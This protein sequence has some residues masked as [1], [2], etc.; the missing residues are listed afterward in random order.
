MSDQPTNVA[1][2]AENGADGELVF[3]R[4]VLDSALSSTGV[5]VTLASGGEEGLTFPT[6][7][8]FWLAEGPHDDLFPDRHQSLSQVTKEP[9]SE[10]LA[11][12]LTELD[13]EAR[14]R[15]DENSLATLEAILRYGLASD[16][17]LGYIGGRSL[18]VTALQ[19]VARFSVRNTWIGSIRGPVMPSD[20]ADFAQIDSDLA[21]RES[22]GFISGP[23]RSTFFDDRLNVSEGPLVVSRAPGTPA[24]AVQ[25]DIATQQDGCVE[26]RTSQGDGGAKRTTTSPGLRDAPEAGGYYISVP[27]LGD[28]PEWVPFLYSA[29]DEAAAG[30]SQ[31]MHGLTRPRTDSD[32]LAIGLSERYAP[33]VAGSERERR[34]LDIAT[35]E[36]AM[37][38]TVSRHVAF[39]LLLPEAVMAPAE[40]E[41]KAL[42]AVLASCQD[43]LGRA[44]PESA[45]SDHLKREWDETS[46][47]Q[48]RLMPQVRS[49]RRQLEHQLVDHVGGRPV[50][51]L[52]RARLATF[53]P[54]SEEVK[55]S[56]NRQSTLLQV[57]N[58]LSP[59]EIEV[60]YRLFTT[61]APSGELRACFEVEATVVGCDAGEA[62]AL[63][64]SFGELVHAAFVGAYGLTFTFSP[65]RGGADDEARMRHPRFEREI[66][67]S[68]DPTGALLPF[69]GRPDWGY[70]LDYLLTLDDPVAIK[71]RARAGGSSK[72][73][74]LAAGDVPDRSERGD[75][76]ATS[77]LND[78]LRRAAQTDEQISLRVSVGSNREVSAPLL[79]LVGTEVSGPATFEVAGVD[80]VDRDPERARMTLAEAFGIFHAPYGDFFTTKIGQSV[81]RISSAI[82]TFPVAGIE[83]GSA[84]RAHAKADRMIKLRISETDALRHLYVVGRTGSGKTNFLRGL[85]AQHLL[86]PGTGIAVIDPHGDLA[87]HVLNSVPAA[88]VDEVVTVDVTDT[89]LMPVLNPL[90]FD[91]AD[92]GARSRIVQDVLELIKQRLY[93][94]WSGPR[95]DEMVRLALD[96][97]LDGGYPVA[98]SL[99]DVPR[100]LTDAGLQTGLIKRLRDPELVARWQFHHRLTTT[101]E[102]PDL[103]DWVVSKFDDIS[104]DESL[105]MILG[106]ERN[107]VDI[108]RVVRENGILIVRLPEAEV[109]RQAAEFVGSLVLQQLRGALL[110]RRASGP[111]AGHFFVY[112]DEFQKFATTAFAELVAE[113]RKY[114]VGMVLAHQ[115]LEQLKAFSP[116]SGQHDQSLLSAILGNV[117]SMVCFGVGAPDTET[118]ASQLGVSSAS[119][120][121]I[122]RYEALARVSL[123]G[124]WVPTMTLVTRLT[125]PELD[126]RRQD[127]I[128]AFQYDSGR[129]VPRSEILREIET[130]R[131]ALT[132][133][134]AATT[135]APPAAATTATTFMEEWRAARDSGK[136]P[137]AAPTLPVEEASPD[138]ESPGRAER[139]ERSE[140]SPVE[141][142]P[143][144]DDRGGSWADVI[145]PVVRLPQVAEAIGESVDIV[146][147][148]AEARRMLILR[149]KNDTEVV[150]VSHFNDGRVVLGLDEVLVA[151]SRSG[152][153]AWST[154]AWLATP[155]GG[156]GGKSVIEWLRAGLDPQMP[157]ILAEGVGDGE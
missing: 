22:I 30:I 63:R 69:A 85:A 86:S 31:E 106:G 113:A 142:G 56:L 66:L 134:V 1:P 84:Y 96:T 24:R 157:S 25:I 37:T 88:R 99:T 146:R 151:L 114:G 100:I 10:A 28:A 41:Y 75:E 127:E 155:Q 45:L 21:R 53:S 124:A 130:R 111:G 38:G 64:A 19:R 43:A 136:P 83:L 61:P 122:G 14:L 42:G 117:G 73:S 104:R 65:S 68:R 27:G 120:A 72:K 39:P 12:R 108:D 2:N 46:A 77:V 118:L 89:E 107:T 29:L 129:M 55:R 135:D 138:R 139:K 78:V 11:T 33:V 149:T 95:F 59:L 23:D 143:P 91:G 26:L 60:A 87:S 102:Y 152:W 54:D 32:L 132:D 112:V 82:D 144:A 3:D 71:L 121:R 97:M 79:S 150:P 51:Y 125:E 48:D 44:T 81:T 70:I 92:A 105:R 119:V 140:G 36:L 49:S 90:A 5:E 9:G 128:R 148:R 6:V 62:A 131:T 18:P 126:P 74:T 67:R 8:F 80:E 16:V 147:G 13:E 57:L 35:N 76:T 98:P 34:Y 4:G 141:H 94:E 58:A 103:M 133:L 40:L 156:L 154:A 145:G 15:E 47:A 115:N 109:G 153:S 93:H 110:R 101:R 137:P 17:H 123:D 116:R 50:H 20:A 52:F 7:G